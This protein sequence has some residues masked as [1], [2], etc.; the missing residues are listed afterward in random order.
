M[1]RT[2]AITLVFTLLTFKSIGQ[3]KALKFEE[4]DELQGA[5]Q[6]PVIVLIMTD[7]CKFCHAMQNS[8]LRNQKLQPLVSSKF[9]TVFLDAEERSDILFAGRTFKY[10][11]GINQLARELAT[12]N[13]KISYP[14][15]CILNSNSEIIYQ[16]EGYLSP[17]ELLYTLKKITEI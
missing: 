15:L 6:K 14:T 12:K 16:H 7:W 17:Q 3:S 8:L 5:V 10:K 9:Y 1:Y 11:S 2:L 13:G 4:L